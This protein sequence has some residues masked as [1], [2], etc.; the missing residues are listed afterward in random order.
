MIRFIYIGEEINEGETDFAFFDTVTSKFKEFSGFQVWSNVEDF[1][2]DYEG[3]E[4]DRYLGKIPEFVKK[5][6]RTTKINCFRKGF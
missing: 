5:L 6:S 3:N 1:V 2:S 4:I